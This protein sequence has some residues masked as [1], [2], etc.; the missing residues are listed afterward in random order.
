[1][2]CVDACAVK[3]QCSTGD[4]RRFPS[5]LRGVR[6]FAM[7]RIDEN[8]L[9]LFC[10]QICRCPRRK[11]IYLNNNVGRKINAEIV[12]YGKQRRWKDLLQLYR[13]ERIRFNAV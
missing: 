12:A 3:Q 1:M 7:A 9:L 13:A 6:M 5:L 2:C 8:L 11:P 10:R 4:V